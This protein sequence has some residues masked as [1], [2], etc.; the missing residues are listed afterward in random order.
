MDVYPEKVIA[1]K[2]DRLLM[3]ALIKLGREYLKSSLGIEGYLAMYHLEANA[4]DARAS[5]IK[6]VLDST[7]VLKY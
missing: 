2:D 4:V 3:T 6:S 7:P 5:Q 1:A